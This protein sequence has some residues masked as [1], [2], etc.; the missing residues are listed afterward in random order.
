MRTKI[1]P[2]EFPESYKY[3]YSKSFIRP[4]QNITVKK[5]KYLI[6]FGNDS[7]AHIFNGLL[8]VMPFT[9][10]GAGADVSVS[11]IENVREWRKKNVRY[12]NIDKHR[13]GV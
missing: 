10:V 9:E 8:L 4:K 12:A 11:E 1:K 13:S 6:H 3:M 5:N 2:S 7:A